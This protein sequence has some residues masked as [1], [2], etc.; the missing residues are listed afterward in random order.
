MVRLTD[1]KG[2]V[3]LFGI[4]QK[5]HAIRTMGFT[6]PRGWHMRTYDYFVRLKNPDWLQARKVVLYYNGV[7]SNEVYWTKTTVNASV[8]EVIFPLPRALAR[9]TIERSEITHVRNGL[10]RAG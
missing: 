3:T 8:D 4:D 10:A 6:T 9:G 1:P 5:T 2:G 7:K